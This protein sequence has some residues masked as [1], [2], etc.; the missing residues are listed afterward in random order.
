MPG[1]LFE[2]P[3]YIAHCDIE[4]CEKCLNIKPDFYINGCNT[5]RII[6]MACCLNGHNIIRNIFEIQLLTKKFA[7]LMLYYIEFVIM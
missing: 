1:L 6:S 2:W 3:K 4:K 5:G 7:H